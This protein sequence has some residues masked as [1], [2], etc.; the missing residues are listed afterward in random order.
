MMVP[1]L[2]NEMIQMSR[3]IENL[4]VTESKIGGDLP[5]RGERWWCMYVCMY[6]VWWWGRAEERRRQGEDFSGM[7]CHVMTGPGGRLEFALLV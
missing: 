4:C 6:R 5:L 3:W 7:S 1:I 2:S